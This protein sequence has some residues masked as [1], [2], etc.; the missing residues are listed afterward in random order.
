MIAYIVNAVIIGAMA[1][2]FYKRFVPKG[3]KWCF[4]SALAVKLLAGVALGLL[5]YEYYGFGDT[6]TYHHDAI[7][8]SDLAFNDVFGYLEI[9]LGKSPNFDVGEFTYS[10]QPRAF[11]LVKILSV[12]HLISDQNYWMSGCYFSLFS[13]LGFWMLTRALMQYFPSIRLGVIVSL[14]FFPSVVFWSS[15][16]VK[17]SLAM[18]ALTLLIKLVL[19]WLLARKLSWKRLICGAFLMVLVWHL[20]YYYLGVFLIATMPMIV[21]DAIGVNRKFKINV[22]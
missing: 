13:F 21:A 4:F 5:Y 3:L 2:L 22:T 20:K 15:G 7:I 18:G 8:L 10:N 1:Y 17:E 19:D 16:I 9:L 6:I 14:L 12:V 11:F